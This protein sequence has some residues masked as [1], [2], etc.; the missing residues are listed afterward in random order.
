MKTAVAPELQRDVERLVHRKHHDPHTLLGAHPG[1]DGTVVR[2]YRP[3]AERVVARADSGEAVE[4][5]KT[6][7]AGLFEGTFEG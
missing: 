3:S 2:A 4:L 7:P 1:K 6:H 5:E